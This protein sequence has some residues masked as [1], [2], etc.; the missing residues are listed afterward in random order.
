M[1]TIGKLTP[2]WWYNTALQSIMDS[3]AAGP[4][5]WGLPLIVVALFALAY[6][7]VGLMVSRLTRTRATLVA[8]VSSDPSMIG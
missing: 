1:Q 2:G 3:R 8:P 7:C 4:T 6:A 5:S